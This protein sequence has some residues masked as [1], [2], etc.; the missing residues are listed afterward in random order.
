[1]AFFKSENLKSNKVFDLKLEKGFTMIELLV[2]MLILLIIVFAF[3]PLFVGSIERIHFAGDKSEA[4]YESQFS[5]EESIAEQITV[6][7]TE[8]IFEY[9]DTL[10]KV[11]GGLIDVETP[12][13]QAS[14]W[15]SG[16]VPFVPTAN[17]FP[18]LVIEGYDPMEIVAM[19]RGTDGGFEIAEQSGGNFIIHDKNKIQVG[20]P[21]PIKN[22]FS[23]QDIPSGYEHLSEGYEEYALFDLTTSLLNHS[24]PYTVWLNWFIEGDI[25]VIVRARIQVVLP[26]AAAVCTG[27]RLILSPNARGTWKTKMD[28]DVGLGSLNDITWNGFE[29]IGVTGNGRIFLWRD[30]RHITVLSKEAGNYNAITSGSGRVVAVGNGG[31]VS[32]AVV[33]DDFEDYNVGADINLLT[34]G[35]SDAKNKF[36]AA[37]EEGKIFLSTNGIVW[38]EPELLEMDVDLIQ[39]NIT[40]NGVS[41]GSGFWL[42]VGKYKETDGSE[43]AIIFKSTLT[44]W[45]ELKDFPQ[46][47]F[48]N[49]LNDVIYDGIRFIIVGNNGTAVYYKPGEPEDSWEFLSFSATV[50]N[51]LLAIDWA[52]FSEEE[53]NYLIVGENETIISWTGDLN[54]SWIVQKHGTTGLRDIRGVAL[55]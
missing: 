3:T 37:G 21:L 31:L 33:T 43:R 55:R 27:Q 7:G 52:I 13:N 41:H 47:V 2:A 29:Y 51:H 19:G 10:I 28:F 8:I 5:L 48:G 42:V 38:G 24:S 14:A 23:A 11:P 36:I 54:D 18:M 44:G 22:Y 1:M 34:V 26:Y 17:L 46:A 30:R 39:E 50:T 40:F 6:D 49:I 9:G 16:F 45:I 4:L 20:S 15:L 12:K 25:E 53:D 35:W 32:T